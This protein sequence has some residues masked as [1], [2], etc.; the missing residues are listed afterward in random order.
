VSEG[1]FGQVPESDAGG[2]GMHWGNLGSAANQPASAFDPA[3]AAADARAA[4][5]AASLPVLA[6]ASV[7]ASAA[8]ALNTITTVTA[9]SGVAAMVLPTPVAG[10]LI[11]VERASASTQNVTVTGNI[12]GVPS[13]T[14]TL[15]LSAESEMFFSTGASWWPLAGH[16]TLGSLQALFAPAA[17]T[18]FVSPVGVA[19]SGVSLANNGAA[20]GPDTP[21]TVSSGIQEAVTYATAQAL[22]SS[23]AAPVVQLL[24]GKFTL[25]QFSNATYRMAVAIDAGY[26]AASG[27]PV[28]VTIR[29]TGTA[30]N[31]PEGTSF[32]NAFTQ[33]VTVIDA[34]GLDVLA[35]GLYK[36]GR[37]FGVVPRL[38]NGT[39]LLNAPLNA[40]D[41]RIE[42]MTI[43]VPVYNAAG[44]GSPA[45]TLS[46]VSS[47]LFV[48]GN[49]QSSNT[50]HWEFVNGID[51]FSASSFRVRNVNV[52]SALAAY[53]PNGT[54]FGGGG[55][56]FS[57]G[58]AAGIVFPHESNQGNVYFENVSTY[59]LHTSMMISTH[60]DG[61]QL[62]SQASSHVLYYRSSGHGARI[63]RMNP[64]SCNDLIRHLLM[65]QLTNSL[66][67]AYFDPVGD[68]Y[69]PIGLT[70]P[71]AASASVLHIGE[72]SIESSMNTFLTDDP[73]HPLTVIAYADYTGSIP[74]ANWGAGANLIVNLVD[75]PGHSQT[76]LAGTTAGSVTWT[77]TGSTPWDKRFVAFLNGYSNTTVTAQT[78]IFLLPYSAAPAVVKDATSASTATATTLTLPASMG[79]PVTG[80]IILE[81]Y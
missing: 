73:S 81:G 13:V 24:G 68:L 18:V 43:I 80:Y 19:T 54:Q 40:V 50:T 9:T 57:Y 53:N 17:G 37:V 27:P 48:S 32:G 36:Q 3:G 66:A 55:G 56:V 79:S 62:Y 76:V 34:S 16:K 67:G 10:A 33:G 39:G 46:G 12:R 35:G 30:M 51:A 15:S 61:T 78:I 2:Q 45:Y 26:S 74:A 11:V 75:V 59:D 52:T 31:A 21:G 71:T 70:F 22:G 49:S 42:N 23:A 5:T 63:G 44:T 4:A 6:Q 47:K 65:P 28:S 77:L 29:G 58:S 14:I 8:L 60:V 25:A 41:L 69:T 64:Q 72:A 20:Y 7:T 38:A 1:Q